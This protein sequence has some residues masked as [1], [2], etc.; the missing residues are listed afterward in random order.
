MWQEIFPLTQGRR[1]GSSR[2]IRTKVKDVTRSLVQEN[3]RN[4]VKTL[5]VQGNLLSLVSQEKEDLIWKSTMFQ[6]LKE[7]LENPKQRGLFSMYGM[8]KQYI[9][10]GEKPISKDGTLIPTQKLYHG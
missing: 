4:H 2:T 8:K 9:K 6:G 7:D 5:Q 1:Q 3:L 10:Q